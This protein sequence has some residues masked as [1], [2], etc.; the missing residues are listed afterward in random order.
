M[1][2]TA[3]DWAEISGEF[4]QFGPAAVGFADLA[5]SLNGA[6]LETLWGTEGN[7]NGEYVHSFQ[8]MIRVL[9]WGH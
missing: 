4:G 6:F 3:A 2:P 5:T 8:E 7:F 9:I 1:D